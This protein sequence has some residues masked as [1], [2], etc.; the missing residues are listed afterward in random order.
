LLSKILN[1]NLTDMERL[2]NREEEI[3]RILWKLKK[4]FVNDIVDAFND[5]KPHYNTVS[6]LIRKME[7][8]GYVQHKAYGKTHQY[9]PMVSV[10]NHKS[11][12]VQNAVSNYFENSYQN[13]VSFFAQQEKISVAELREIIQLI[14]SNPKSE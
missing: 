13:L 14:E 3:M 5:P 1:S 11:D 12:F 6:T 7:E 2:T 4:A 8:K 10:E 9:F